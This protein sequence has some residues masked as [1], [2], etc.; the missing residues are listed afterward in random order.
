MNG[1]AKI[2]FEKWLMNGNDGVSNF[3][4]TIKLTQFNFLSL[5]EIC[6][7]ALIIEFYQQQKRF[8]WERLFYEEY[9]KTNFINSK[10]A[11][12]KAIEKAV[13]IYNNLKQ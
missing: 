6:Q 5:N 2:D 13:E 3:G 9:R 10:L 11:T 12:E 8:D 4:R 1:Q 7:H